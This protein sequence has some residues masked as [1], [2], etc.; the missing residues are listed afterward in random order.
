MRE[1]LDVTLFTLVKMHGK[2]AYFYI[3]LLVT[4]LRTSEKQRTRK[5]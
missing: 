4:D 2:Y 3:Y 5:K 1:N